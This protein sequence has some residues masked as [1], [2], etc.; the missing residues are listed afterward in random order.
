[1]AA[2][3][4]VTPTPEPE[5][6]VVVAQASEEPVVVESTQGVGDN[7]ITRDSLDD[8][9][10][11]LA[12]AAEEAQGAGDAAREQLNMDLIGKEVEQEGFPEE[13]G[14]PCTAEGVAEGGASG[15]SQAEFASEHELSASMP[16]EE[17]YAEEEEEGAVRLELKDNA[18]L[19]EEEAMGKLAGLE[20]A[21]KVSMEARSW[22][23]C[24]VIQ[25]EMD[26][27]KDCLK[28][29]HMDV[30]ASTSSIPSTPASTSMNRSS[31]GGTRGVANGTPRATTQPKWGDWRAESKEGKDSS[32]KPRRKPKVKT[33]FPPVPDAKVVTSPGPA[34]A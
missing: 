8:E 11:L 1:M 15:E 18:D 17:E 7:N 16:Q 25:A 9:S 20:I 33:M 21:M 13:E 3:Q 28:E 6:E 12:P 32:T 10:M 30:R 22:A 23:R 24:Q 14:E 2:I 34:I 29:Q 27:I 31:I 4:N 26:A 19:T 5:Q